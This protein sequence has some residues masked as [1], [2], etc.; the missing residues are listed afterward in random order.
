MECSFF[1]IQEGALK[2]NRW[3]PRTFNLKSSKSSKER[4]RLVIKGSFSLGHVL[5]CIDFNVSFLCLLFN[6]T[7]GQSLSLLQVQKVKIIS[8][9]MRI[10]DRVCCFS[11]FSVL[12][13]CSLCAVS[14][15]YNVFSQKEET[16]KSKI[17]L[18]QVM[19]SFFEY[20]LFSSLFFQR[21]CMRK[22]EFLDCHFFLFSIRL[23]RQRA[24]FINYKFINLMF[25]IRKSFILFF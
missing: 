25:N 10:N 11:F 2:L 6:K 17:W 13:R 1:Y 4:R 3:F 8:S 19:H 7:F 12:L 23:P 20:L 22:R 18:W 9:M 5:R 24:L 14:K 21:L 16:S 15:N